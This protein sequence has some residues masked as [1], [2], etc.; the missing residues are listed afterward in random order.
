MKHEWECLKCSNPIDGKISTIE[1]EVGLWQ[2]LSAQERQQRAED[3]GLDHAAIEAYLSAPKCGT[4]G[5]QE[6]GKSR[7][8]RNRDWSV[9]FVSVGAGVLLAAK[10]IQSEIA[11]SGQAFSEHLGQA[12]R[13]SFLNPAPVVTAHRRAPTCDCATRGIENFRKLW[14][15]SF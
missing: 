2:A 8:L 4:L 13:F 6:I 9:G 3:Y 1:E 14:V 11:G 15:K 7:V 12:L 10:V 5:E